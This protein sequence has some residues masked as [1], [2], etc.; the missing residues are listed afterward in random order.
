MAQDVQKEMIVNN[1]TAKYL[2]ALRKVN[3]A[4][5]EGLQTAIFVLGKEEKSTPE[6]R[7]SMIRSRRGMVAQC[8][9]MY[10]KAPT[11]H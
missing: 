10:G 2:W 4:L 1:G 3:E 7:K 8:E 9:E 6:E 11:R 5:L